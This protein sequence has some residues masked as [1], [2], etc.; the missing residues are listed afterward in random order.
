M[1]RP[2][3]LTVV[4]LTCLL[5]GN[6]A[7]DD[8]WRQENWKRQQEIWEKQ[9]E[10]AR[11]QQKKHEEFLQEDHKRR[12]EYA[13]E[14]QKRYEEQLREQWKRQ[15]EFKKERQKYYRENGWSGQHH[16]NYDGHLQSHGRGNAPYGRVIV[17]QERQWRGSI[18]FEHAPQF[19][20]VYRGYPPQVYHGGPYGFSGR[21]NVVP[22]HYGVLPHGYK[23]KYGGDDDDDDD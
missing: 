8:D 3:G 15:H 22:N 11:E 1:R 20:P 21:V 18:Q 5:I 2:A 23:P 19:G 12:E 10:W 17:P 14:A 7:A 6:A 16:W 9:Q 13:R 4:C